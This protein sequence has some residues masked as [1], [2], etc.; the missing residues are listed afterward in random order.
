MIHAPTRTR[1]TEAGRVNLI[2]LMITV[3]LAVGGLLAYL[4]APYHLD[5]M[6]MKEV[7]S[8][9]SLA[10]YANDAKSS[11]ERKLEEQL[12]GKEID[13][14]TRKDNC[15]FEEA[16]GMFTTYCSWEVDVYY[17]FTDFYKTIWY[18][19]TAECDDR[20]VVSVY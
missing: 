2:G 19:V 6:N 4:F 5:Y 16:A 15:S 20:G 14:I 17:P 7:V 10:W 1:R 11:G 12:R 3:V 9:A 13:Y 18:E 8:S